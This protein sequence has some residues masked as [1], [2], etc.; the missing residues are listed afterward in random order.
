M[1][2]SVLEQGYVTMDASLVAPII[3][4]VIAGYA[5]LGGVLIW[6][7]KTTSAQLD[8]TNLQFIA[9]LQS[10][11]IESNKNSTITVE[12]LTEVVTTIREMAATNRE[13]HRTMQSNMIEQNRALLDAM[14]KVGRNASGNY[15]AA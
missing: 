8:R 10:T 2:A 11:V 3:T 14:G 6:M 13:E 9:A 4:A 1:L 7:L 15:Q 12:R 5:A